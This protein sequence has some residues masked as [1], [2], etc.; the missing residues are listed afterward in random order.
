MFT[1]IVEEIGTIRQVEK[2]RHSAVLHISASE[3]LTDIHIGDSIA[4]NGVC[5]TVTAV[6]AN[7]FAADAMHETLNRTTLAA[8]K[9]GSH[10]NLERA[11]AAN[12]RFGGHIVAGHVDGVGTIDK[13]QQDDTAIW[14]TIK[15]EPPILR[16][17]IEKG[18]VAVD[19]I[20]LTVARVSPDRFAVSV[21]P[22]TVR[23]TVLGERREGDK[24]NLENDMVGKYV[25][26]LLCKDTANDSIAGRPQSTLTR[27]FLSK[28]GY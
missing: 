18:S 6:H 10:V 28:C 17:I 23:V 21:I 24:V 16:Y 20:S 2:G 14:Y 11:M 3:I 9:N 4:V 8:L 22:H 25:E 5:L 15:A 13:L 7:G 19:G 12:G 1:G 26:K 27:E